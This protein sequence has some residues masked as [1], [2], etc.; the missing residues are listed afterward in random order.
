[1]KTDGTWSLV[2]NGV[3]VSW[4]SSAPVVEINIEVDSTSGVSV[5]GLNESGSAFPTSSGSVSVD[6][7]PVGA[8]YLVKVRGAISISGTTIDWTDFTPS[9]QLADPNNTNSLHGFLEASGISGGNGI[10]AFFPKTA[11]VS[12]RS[13]MG[14]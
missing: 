14:V 11:T 1:M 12:L 8:N 4:L 5:S 6:P 13:Q 7:R 10:R 9:V 3:S 2:E